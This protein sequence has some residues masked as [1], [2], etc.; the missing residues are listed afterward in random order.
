MGNSWAAANLAK[1]VGSRLTAYAERSAK[2]ERVL[3]DLYRNMQKVTTKLGKTGGGDP[4]QTQQEIV[5]FNQKLQGVNENIKWGV[6]RSVGHVIRKYTES[7]KRDD[8]K[9]AGKIPSKPYLWAQ[10]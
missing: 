9:G 1:A 4:R 5:L 10:E 6:R 7:T 2:R 8:T 3:V